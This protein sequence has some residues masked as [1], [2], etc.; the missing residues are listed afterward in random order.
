MFSVL[1]RPRWLAYLALAVL[2]GII[3]ANLGLWQWHRHE[4]KVERRDL[5]ER[6]YDAA[7]VPVGD[8]LSGPGGELPEGDQWRRVEATGTY[9]VDAQHWVRNRPHLG[10]Y[11][12]E[13]VVP[14][15]LEDGTALTVDRGWVRNAPVAA[16]LPEVPDPPSG[17][18]TVTGWLRPSEQDLGRDMPEHQLASIDIPRLSAAS[19]LELLPAYILLES[20]DPAPDE[21]PAAAEPPDTLLGSHF[22][23]AIQWWLTVPV[24]LILVLVMARQIARDEAEESGGRA[25]GSGAV[26]SGR[27]ARGAEPAQPKAKK[28]TKVRIW[29]E[30][31]A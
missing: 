27:V 25:V 31:D 23:Y 20:E 18:V 26:G 3:T 16:Q 30:E 24:G 21:R 28:P 6:N 10:V 12:F 22:A 1:R 8:V 11:G 15:V 9:A 13:I 4:E 7:P 17:E 29:D 2:F 14:L 19:G 5:I